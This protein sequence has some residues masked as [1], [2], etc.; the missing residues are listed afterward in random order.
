MTNDYKKALLK[1]LTGKI[2]DEET[3]IGV[4]GNFSEQNT[5]IN[6]LDDYLNNNLGSS[7]EIRGTLQNEN[8]DNY[9]LYGDYRF[10]GAYYGFLLIVDNDFNPIILI[11]TYD[12]GTL[13][14]RFYK[15]ELDEKN[16]IYGIDY[17]LD[18]SQY[19]FIMLNNVFATGEAKL[20]QSYNITSNISD[21]EK[22]NFLLSKN[23]TAAEYLIADVVNS[24]GITQPKV[25]QLTI[26]VG[27]ANEWTAYTYDNSFIGT[28]VSLD[29]IYSTWNEEMEFKL[30][31][32]NNDALVIYSNTNESSITSTVYD[33]LDDYG[34]IDVYNSTT[35]IASPNVYFYSFHA[36]VDGDEILALYEINNNVKTMIYSEILDGTTLSDAN[37]AID[38][39]VI[40]GTLFYVTKLPNSTNYDLTVGVYRSGIINETNPLVQN[41]SLTSIKQF[42]IINNF[43]LYKYNYQNGD[44]LYSVKLLYNPNINFKPHTAGYNS[45]TD[46]KP[47]TMSIYSN[48]GLLFNRSLYNLVTNASTSTA[49]VE[50]PNTM[51]NEINI[52]G[53][54]LIGNHYLQIAQN[55]EEIQTNIYE[56]LHINI[57]NTLSMINLDT[58]ILNPSG[59]TRLNNSVNASQD[60]TNAQAKKIKINY[61]DGTNLIQTLGN[62]QISETSGIYTY[63]FMVYVPKAIT[64]VQII[65]NDETTVYQTITG[66]FEVG[67]Y[68]QITQELTI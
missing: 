4:V 37:I 43:N 35:I 8:Y 29:S 51:L 46:L 33:L 39:K 26:N 48:G 44:N 40:N 32:Y 62:S 2:Q 41:I 14:G 55:T 63:T 5:E 56:T 58:G 59:S 52:E 27:Q 28:G 12:T 24:G 42:A 53:E 57:I 13:L 30:S 23:P 1:Y 65:S 67:K 21:L 11:K 34:N 47:L 22:V 60:Y 20:R 64:N 68:Y 18:T 49:T 10:S 54:N 25:Y 38:L 9:I 45:Y 31:G 15:L 7:F 3:P 19:R 61:D 36:E 6:A 66:T 17:N 50:V 16:Q